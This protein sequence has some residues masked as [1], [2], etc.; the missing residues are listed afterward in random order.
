MN[1]L[2]SRRTLLKCGSGGLATLVALPPLE[3]MFGSDSAYAQATSKRSRFLAMYTPNG[4]IQER[5]APSAAG[6]VVRNFSLT[7]TALAPL[8]RHK[9]DLTVFRNLDN[10]GKTGSGNAHMRAIAGFLTGVAI[11]NDTISRHKI[12]IDQWIADEAQRRG[13]TPIH[14]LQLAGNN[15]LDPPNN[16]RYNNLLK[17]SLSFD[18]EGRI[19]P[20]T[21]NLK[22]VFERLFRGVEP[23]ESDA[24]AERRALMRNSVLDAVRS[25]RAALM[26]KLGTSDQRRLDEYFESLRALELDLNNA[27]PACSTNG[28]AAPSATP[29]GPRLNAIGNHA[30]L[31]G[32]V[33]ALAFRCD[34]T[35]SATYMAGGEATGCGYSELSINEHFHNSISHNR[36]GKA[37]L[38]HQIDTFHSDLVASW[39]DELSDTPYGESTLLDGTA[40]L[41]GAGLGNADSHS[42]SNIGL[43]LAGRFGNIKQGALRNMNGESHARVLHTI[44][45]ELGLPSPFGSGV[46]TLDLTV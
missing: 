46:D 28:T 29:D 23:G 21:A 14:S 2:I 3:A 42:L 7:G 27:L 5:W 12:S 37:N 15:E 9:S 17:N 33:L 6:A 45:S 38:H 43:V 32:K 44:V 19:L 31:T 4:T 36:A 18:R 25:D 30:K 20:N 13:A 34:L 39:L 10:A 1:K 26:A 35:N 16:T 24:A 40:V 11:P 22:L 41:Y 8:E